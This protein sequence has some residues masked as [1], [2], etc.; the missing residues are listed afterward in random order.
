MQLI[1]VFVLAYAKS[2]FSHVT[3]YFIHIPAGLEEDSA[4]SLECFS[5]SAHL[6]IAVPL[7]PLTLTLGAL[8]YE[9]SHGKTAISIF[10][11]QWCR[12]AA[13][14]YMLMCTCVV[15]CLDR[16]TFVSTLVNF[17]SYWVCYPPLFSS[18]EPKAHR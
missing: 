7:L 10:K 1:C 6:S 12:S 9:L 15:C 5:V 3:A 2:R 16:V 11:N 13:H 4:H 17:L 8:S 18:P 14:T